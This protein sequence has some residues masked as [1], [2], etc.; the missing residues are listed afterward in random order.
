MSNERLPNYLR[1]CR[2]SARLS[3]EELARLLGCRTGSKVSRYEHFKQEPS[4]RTA[5]ACEAVFRIPVRELFAGFADEIERE[6]AIRARR[7]AR[8]LR[9]RH[10]AKH[11][12]RKLGALETASTPSTVE[13][14]YE[15]FVELP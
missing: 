6:V 8:V 13:L 3:Q 4:L 12:T 14:V 7:M 10:N 11:V 1:R 15:P 2:K 5:L 9:A